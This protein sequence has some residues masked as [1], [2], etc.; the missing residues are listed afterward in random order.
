[1][2]DLAPT[3]LVEL[4]LPIASNGGQPFERQLFD[5]VR[6]ELLETFGGVTLFSR[7]PAEGLW[8]AGEPGGASCDQMIAVEVMTDAID[9]AWWTDY[10]TQLQDRFS[11]REVLIRCH[12]VT[13]L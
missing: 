2:I 6:D 9:A 10:R 7:S 12:Q 3:Y 11:Q 5:C 4:F 8:A 1:M 13:K